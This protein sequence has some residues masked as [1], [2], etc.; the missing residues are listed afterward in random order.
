MKGGPSVKV[1]IDLALG[2]NNGVV[3]KAVNI[4]KQQVFLYDPDIKRLQLAYRE[5]NTAAKDILISYSKAEFFSN[6][7]EIE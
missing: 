3:K 5:G 1:L 7:P 2:N 4:L 6:L